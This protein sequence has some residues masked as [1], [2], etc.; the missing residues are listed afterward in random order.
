MI[1]VE[2]HPDQWSER[3]ELYGNLVG[4]TYA[5]LAAVTP[6]DAWSSF[7]ELLVQQYLP[8]DE[9]R[10]MQWRGFKKILEHAYGHVPFYRERFQRAGITPADIR[11][12]SDI[13]AIPL[14]SRADLMA[15]FPDESRADNIAAT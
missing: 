12:A 11:S 6:F 7:Q 5:A 10:A 2:P 13:Q 3:M 15:A 14:T 4:K 1:H 8:D 9:L